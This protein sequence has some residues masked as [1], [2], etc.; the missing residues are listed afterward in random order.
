MIDK[1]HS[2]AFGGFVFERGILDLGAFRS[3][4]QLIDVNV[5]TLEVLIVK[6]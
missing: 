3:A 5:C 6:K 2:L 1:G 4:H